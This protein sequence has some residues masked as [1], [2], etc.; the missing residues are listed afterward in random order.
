MSGIKST[1]SIE[2]MTGDYKTSVTK[3]LSYL[4][5][6]KPGGAHLLWPHMIKYKLNLLRIICEILTLYNHPFNVKEVLKL[7][8]TSLVNKT[9]DEIIELFNLPR[10][11]KKQMAYTL[12][13]NEWGP[14]TWDWLHNTTIMIDSAFFIFP[15]KRVIIDAIDKA[16]RTQFINLHFIIYCAVCTL[17]FKQN[18]NESILQRQVI[19]ADSSITNQVFKFHNKVNLTLKKREFTLQEFLTSRSC[20]VY[21]ND[22]Y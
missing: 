1:K 11:P 3:N 17:H 12:F 21:T 9:R 5:D 15:E 14:I 8:P 7:T 2:E 10:D 22:D 13:L 6:F 19:D 20:I 18:Y 16:F 4:I